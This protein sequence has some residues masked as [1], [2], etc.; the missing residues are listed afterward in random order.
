MVDRQKAIE[1]LKQHKAHEGC[2]EICNNGVSVTYHDLMDAYDLA[3]DSIEK[4]V[5]YTPPAVEPELFKG[6]GT[7]R[8]CACGIYFAER[9]LDGYC[10]ICGQRLFWRQQE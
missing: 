7:L 8:K 1:I 3:I 4:T 5:P 2:I 10:N 9:D 6:A